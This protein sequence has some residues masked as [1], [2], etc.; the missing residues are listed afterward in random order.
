MTPQVVANL[1]A[2]VES[3]GDLIT[4]AKHA[5][6]LPA[7]LTG[8]KVGERAEGRT[9]RV[10]S[11]GR[12][13]A[14]LP[15]AYAVLELAG[16]RPLLGNESGHALVAVNQVGSGR[17]I[18]GAA[19]FWMTDRITY[20][21]P[22]LVNMEPPFRLLEGVKQVLAG[23]FGSFSPVTVS[24]EGLNIRT[25]C[26]AA[27]QKRMLVGLTNNDLFA[28]WEGELALRTGEAASARDL[29]SGQ[30]I[31]PGRTLRVRVP[32]GDVAMIELRLR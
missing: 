6:A 17:V 1:R 5:A 11:S 22:E 15:Y 2:F 23:Y 32:A 4:D 25:S 20:A 7:E 3:G 28:D 18:V 24:P 12:V 16:A 19:D 13:N 30:E 9:S 21:A 8:V 31:A 10:L 29:W 14:E 27:D 26:Y